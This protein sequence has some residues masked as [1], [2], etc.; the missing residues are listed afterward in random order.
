[1]RNITN[2]GASI[3]GSDAAALMRSEAA[4]EQARAASD[5]LAAADV[6]ALRMI[7]RDCECLSMA[8][9]PDG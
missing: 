1:M 3:H 7:V 2:N 9:M 6:V 8:C 4:A 5:R